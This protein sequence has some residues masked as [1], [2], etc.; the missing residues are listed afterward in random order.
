MTSEETSAR[1]TTRTSGINTKL[2]PLNVARNLGVCLGHTLPVR[3]R[4]R[5]RRWLWWRWPS[6]VG[7]LNKE[8]CLLQ[9]GPLFPTTLRSRSLGSVSTWLVA[10]S[11]GERAPPGYVQS[12]ASPRAA[13]TILCVMAVAFSQYSRD[14]WCLCSLRVELDGA[15]CAWLATQ[16]SKR[17]YEYVRVIVNCR[18]STHCTTRS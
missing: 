10:S 6:I 15:Y 17:R 18:H 8:G 16:S 9:L 13:R 14:P 1:Q 3:R 2:W 11:G 4:P 7:A 12:S 5:Q